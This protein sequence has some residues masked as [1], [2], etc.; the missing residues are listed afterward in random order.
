L[1]KDS[2][3]HAFDF[4]D[5]FPDRSAL[6]PAAG[7]DDDDR[8]YVGVG[9]HFINKKW[10]KLPFSSKHDLSVHY[11]ISQ[12]AFSATYKGLFHEAIGKWDLALK[13]NYDAV[14]WTFFHGL[15]NETP[16][17][18]DREFFQ[19]RTKE[20]FGSIGINRKVGRSSFDITGFFNNVKII[21][22]TG[23]FVVKNLLPLDPKL[24]NSNSYAG[25]R[26]GFNIA[27]LN[28]SIVPTRGITFFA[29]ASHI[30]DLRESD[31]S[32]QNFS[33]VV[34]FFVPLVSK[35]SL[36]IKAG[37]ATITETPNFYHYVSIGGAQNLRGFDRDRFWGKSAFYNNNE[38][39]FITPIRSYI[40]NGH[41]G[42]LAFLDDGR[43]WMPSETSDTW[44][45]GYGGG[46]LIA[47]FHL[48]SAQVTY[49]ISKE[50]KY[51]QLQLNKYF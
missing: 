24:F 35:F 29:N 28:D 48:L 21:N 27:H 50:S 34:Q 22:D 38:L 41:I 13:A 33:G 51:L 42:L 18:D 8:L 46:L 7:Y 49:G 30:Q 26:V 6:S 16:F 14:R 45:Y 3:S 23:R 37:A 25:L 39:R 10:R 11:S 40:M 15:G 44:H 5:F 2:A 31:K 32:F 43:V 47:P 19:M 17:I 12:K 4:D 36:A 9:Y 1:I 20:W